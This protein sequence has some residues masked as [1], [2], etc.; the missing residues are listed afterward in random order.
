MINT[1]YL[2]EIFEYK[3]GKLLWKIK[4]ANRIDIGQEAGT[5][6]KKY[7][8]IYIKSKPYMAHKLIYQMFYGQFDGFIDHIDNNSLNNKIENLRLCT[9]Q[10][11]NQNR[12]K[13]YKNKSG[14]KNVYLFKKKWKV[15]LRIN[16]KTTHFG[17]F[18]DIELADLV[19]Q[20]ARNKYHG[21][22]ANHN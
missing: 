12:A 2:H 3:D 20:E 15:E 6:N 8:V 18:D 19:A 9:M 1:E 17:V 14:F 13:S 7:M 22:F 5:D 11:N 16:K 10:Q 21:A 4:Q